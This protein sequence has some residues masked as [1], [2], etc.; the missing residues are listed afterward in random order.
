M[1]KLKQWP[2]MFLIAQTNNY[3]LKIEISLIC[4]G[5]VSQQPPK[6]VAPLLIICF[7]KYKNFLPV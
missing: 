1:K 6:I 5:L 4:D 3:F 2:T 7:E